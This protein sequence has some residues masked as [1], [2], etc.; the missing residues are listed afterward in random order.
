MGSP[1]EAADSLNRDQRRST[2]PMPNTA[3]GTVYDARLQAGPPDERSPMAETL[4]PAPS[5]PPPLPPPAQPAG[6]GASHL[7]PGGMGY[8]L[9]ERIGQGQYGEVYRARA[10]G[11]VLVAVKRILRSL[12]HEASQRE[13]KVLER[14]RDLRHPF[15]LQLHNYYP[16]HDR[17]IVVMELADGSLE[18]R[19][20]ECRAAGEPGVPADELLRYFSE[21]AEA[22]DFLH[23]EKLCHRDVKPQ[24]LLRVRGHAK[25]A[26]FGIARP[27]EQTLDHTMNVGGT[28]SYMPPEVWRG[29]VSPHSDQYALAVTWYEMRTG[30]RIFPR[31]ENLLD[32]AH[33]HLNDRPDLSGVPPAE[34]KVLLRALAKSPDDRYPSCVAFA[35]ALAEALAPPKPR[36]PGPGGGKVAAASLALAGLAL[37]IALYLIFR[38][39]P[40]V[41]TTAPAPPPQSAVDWQPDGWAPE[42]PP[43]VIKDL[44]GR[45]Y[46]R[47]LAR[48]FGGQNV[49]LVAVPQKAPADPRT[50][51]VM[52]NK[53]W[54]DLYAGFMNDP[55]KKMWERFE[56]H[57]GDPRLLGP[58]DEWRKGGWNASLSNDYEKPPF[59][60]VE[61][62]LGRAPVFRVKVTEAHFFAEWLGGRLP[63]AAQWRKAAG[64]GEDSL[65]RSGPFSGDPEDKT[66]LAV[67]PLKGGPWPVDRGD[68]DVSI[69]GCRQMASN[70]K[71]WTRDLI[72]GAGEIPLFQVPPLA[73]S[74]R[75]Q[76]QSYIA[77]GPLTFKKMMEPDALSCAQSSFDVSFRV[78]LEPPKAD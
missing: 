49:V 10:P 14:V 46:Y 12:D 8:E 1:S 64:W 28:P 65:K 63:S 31:K 62:P 72:G 41:P 29:D 59:P 66:G 23:A 5:V 71:E 77:S 9:L 43:E 35:Q 48:A 74:V 56:H 16:L 24:N 20:K 42:G 38:P 55:A 50:F 52:E 7:L 17:L 30:N 57:G 70:G 11:G 26:D 44:A 34:R 6:T 27:Q 54:N 3:P 32:I 40:P 76:G 13:L 39:T 25:V 19:L 67:G 68:R 18:D 58:R 60:G 47:R 75:L 51:Y 53:V 2:D 61:G 73:P 33:Q 4:V 37:L 21:A 69:Y 45:R 36:L 15:L 78:V 22:L